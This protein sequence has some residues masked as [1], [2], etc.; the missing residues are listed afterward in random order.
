VR[1][2]S[3]DR[4]TAGDIVRQGDL[5]VSL[6]D[7]ELQLEHRKWSTKYEQLTKQNRRALADRDAAQVRILTAE[8][9]QARTQLDLLDDQLSRTR[10]VAA[11]DGIIVSG[12]LSQSL[13]A[14]VE[15]GQVLFETAPL[16]AYRVV[17]RVDERD[18]A[19]VRA[20]QEGALLL[21]AFP[22]DAVRFTLEKVTPVS[23]AEEGLNYFR[24]EAE[25][26]GAPARLRPG[27]EGVGKIE[28]DRRHLVWIWTH[29]IVDWLRLKLWRWMP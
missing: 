5:L 28:V 26:E 23:Q 9:E 10:I 22:D 24:A 29:T 15:K 6:E 17:L 25:L 27:M 14:P 18:I 3:F 19:D 13:G 16:E 21:T 20:G 7:R 8:S 4:G 2:I 1:A 12:D 11:F